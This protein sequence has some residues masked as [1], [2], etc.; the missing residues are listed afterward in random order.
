MF[1]AAYDG[2]GTKT[3][4]WIGDKNGNI[5]ADCLGGP[6][7][8]QS[9]GPEETRRVISD[10][11]Q[12]ALQKANL[13]KSDISYAF[14]GLAGADLP[15]DFEMLYE[16]LHPVFGEVPFKIVNDAWII[17][18][19]A[20]TSPWG[21]VCICGTGSNSGA[22]HPDGRQA[23]LRSLGYSL[24][25]YGGGGD[26]TREALHYAF[27]ADE[28]TGPDTLLEKHLP[29]VFGASDMEDLVGK[30][31]PEQEEGIYQKMKKVPPLVFELASKGDKVCQDILIHM[32][33][34]LGDMTA[35]VIKR[36]AMCD[37]EIP[38]VLGGS[39]FHGSNPLLI[40]AFTLAIHR[41]APKAYMLLPTLPPVAGAYL[42]GL[43]AMKVDCGSHVYKALHDNFKL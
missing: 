5:L 23:I 32:G 29:E 30:F 14:L 38:V 27:R 2:G 37:M 6:S 21:A 15:S 26:I 19:S 36:L 43:D 10:L 41:T 35:G 4:C 25:N 20:I 33:E 1:V 16:L 18:R 9:C 42:Y 34:V 31:Y 40:D 3:R 7:N 22:A 8:H 11:L 12:E 24:G 39:V 28:K 17:M 13:Q